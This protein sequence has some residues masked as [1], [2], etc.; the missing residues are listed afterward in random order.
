MEEVHDIGQEHDLS[1]SVI[2]DHLLGLLCHT[3]VDT[4]C[5]AFWFITHDLSSRYLTTYIH[6]LF[7]TLHFLSLKPPNRHKKQLDFKN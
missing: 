5:Q 1:A 4:I 7:R 3:T 2:E 6:H